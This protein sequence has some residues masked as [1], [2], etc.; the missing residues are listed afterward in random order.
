MAGKKGVSGGAR[1]GAGRPKGSL[2]KSTIERA[3]LAERIIAEQK[4]QPG[5]K[6]AREVLDD[7]MHLFTGLAAMHQPLPDNVLP[8]PGQKP[9]EAKFLNYAKLAVDVAGQ[10]A[11]YQS[12]KFKAIVMTGL[13]NNPGGALPTPADVVGQVE[14]VTAQQAYR[15]LRDSDVI[16]ITPNP[17]P[18]QVV[19]IKPKKAARG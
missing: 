17:A 18:A 13:E 11:N 14:Q 4:Q 16:D 8:Q 5:K 12:P 15:M 3:A 7:F 2:S 19:P 6:L 1:T 10:L 9:D